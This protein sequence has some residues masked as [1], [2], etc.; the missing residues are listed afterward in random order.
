M[1]KRITT[2]LLA[3]A[4]TLALGA[5]GQAVASDSTGEPS[6]EE[7]TLV[8]A[9]YTTPREAFAQIIPLFQAQWL[10]QTGQTVT[11]EES[12]QGSGAQSRA[13]VEGFEADIV[14]LSLEADVIRIEEAGL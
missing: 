11:F 7:L 9:A 3:A 4:L 6:G 13:V 8:L 14:A 1:S 12:Y 2:L 10:E 5:C